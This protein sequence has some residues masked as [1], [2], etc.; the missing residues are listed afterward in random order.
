MSVSDGSSIHLHREASVKRLFL[1]GVT[2]VAV[3]AATH[4]RAAD[5]PLKAPGLVPVYNWSTCYVGGNV[6]YG[7]SLDESIAF[8]GSF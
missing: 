2:L 1:G 7:G 6:G 8:T 3:A 5:M 4:V